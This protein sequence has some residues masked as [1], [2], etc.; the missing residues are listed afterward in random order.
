[1]TN[2]ICCLGADNVETENT[3]FLKKLG[4]YGLQ[5]RTSSGCFISNCSQDLSMSLIRTSCG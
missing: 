1:M 4:R 2:D 5:M 3:T